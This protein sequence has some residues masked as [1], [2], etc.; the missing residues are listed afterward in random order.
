MA[1]RLIR[2]LTWLTEDIAKH[3]K[4][5][6]MDWFEKS[7]GHGKYSREWGK[8]W[9]RKGKECWRL[10][11]LLLQILLNLRANDKKEHPDFLHSYSCSC[12]A[13]LSYLPL[14]HVTA[15]QGR[16]IAVW[17]QLRVRDGGCSRSRENPQRRTAM[18]RWF[19]K[20]LNSAM[21]CT[22]LH[23]TIL[24]CS[25]LLCFL[26]VHNSSWWNLTSISPNM[27]QLSLNYFLLYFATQ[28][29]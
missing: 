23:C 21:Y 7:R 11:T 13:T 4:W 28:S 1:R 3:W 17:G 6:L 19:M 18:R 29:S 9:D 12:Y 5:L 25:A 10:A 8:G 14:V 15:L 27:F 16:G 20:P 2:W 26:G 22:I 24:H